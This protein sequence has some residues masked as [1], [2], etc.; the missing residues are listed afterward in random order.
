[1]SKKLGKPDIVKL[2][3]ILDITEA[4]PLASELLRLRGGEMRIDASKVRKLGGQCLQALLCATA[5][6]IQDGAHFEIVHPS[7]EFTQ[8]I[9]AYGLD[10]SHFS[11]QEHAL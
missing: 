7:D 10:L 3:E 9:A 8:S 4:A 6:A 5:T 11:S 2:A 1:M